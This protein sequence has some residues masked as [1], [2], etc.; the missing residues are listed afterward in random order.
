MRFF[1]VHTHIL[2]NIDDGSASVEESKQMIEVLKN[3]GVTDIILT[4]HFYHYEMTLDHFLEKRNEAFSKIEEIFK[5]LGIT[6]H[7]GAEVYLINTLFRYD[8]ISELCIDKGQYILVELP[9]DEKDSQKV[10]K[11]LHKLSANYSVKPILAHIEKY[12]AF[13]NTRFLTEVNKLGYVTQID[14][15][16]LKNPFKKRKIIKFIEKGLIQLAGTDCHNLKERKP[17]LEVLKK[18]VPDIMAEFLFNNSDITFV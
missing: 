12:P 16:S 18:T 17:D 9:F 4:P 6:P 13:F 1:D 5:D 2:P 10:L 15:D 14:V 7:I 8:D 3:Q 11:K